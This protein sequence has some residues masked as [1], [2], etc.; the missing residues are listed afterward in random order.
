MKSPKMA[1]LD[2]VSAEMKNGTIVGTDSNV[3]ITLMYFVP[4]LFT[5]KMGAIIRFT[6]L[7]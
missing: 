3:R 7:T 6:K 5:R 4:E 2:S 1:D